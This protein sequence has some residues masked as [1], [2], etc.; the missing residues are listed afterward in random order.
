MAKTFKVDILSQS[1]LRQL[2]RD[3]ER[4]RDSLQY[5]AELLAKT[6][7]DKG[8]DIA[9]VKI[10]NL[11]AIF[12]GELISS[13]HRQYIGSFYGGAIFAVVA[14]SEHAV[15]VEFGTGH[16]GKDKPYPHAFPTG[17]SWDYATGKTVRQNPI[18]GR[19]Y[20]FYPGDDGKWHYT[21]GMPSRPFMHDTS[22][23][24]L[25]LIVITAKDIFR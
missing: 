25:N 18:T 6:L 19:Y 4:Y 10:A 14:D 7:A 12:T 20:W 2:Q 21:E 23:E 8:V 24:L 9:Q 15:F 16:R 5:K 3:L 1:S 17:I 22:I 13:I 11:D